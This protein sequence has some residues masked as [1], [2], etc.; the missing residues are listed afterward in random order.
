MICG[1]KNE[2]QMIRQSLTNFCL[3][4]FF[5]YELWV[6]VDCLI[7]TYKYGI[8]ITMKWHKQSVLSKLDLLD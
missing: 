3:N 5:S 6:I 4:F 2:N 8:E 1:F 7:E